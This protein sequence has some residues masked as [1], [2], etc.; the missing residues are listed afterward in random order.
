MR[1]HPRFDSNVWVWQPLGEMMEGTFYKMG[2]DTSDTA[3]PWIVVFADGRGGVSAATWVVD[4]PKSNVELYAFYN[5]PIIDNWDSR[6]TSLLKLMTPIEGVPFSPLHET[7]SE[8]WE[9]LTTVV[10][11]EY[12]NYDWMNLGRHP[13][14][15][16]ALIFR[17]THFIPNSINKLHI[18]G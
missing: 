17:A 5:T 15:S 13:G 10:S 6:N 7:L 11:P 2:L 14:S 3:I 18:G 12:G 9:E 4:N 16:S 8:V 1:Y